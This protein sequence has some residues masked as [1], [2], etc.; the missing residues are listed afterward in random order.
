MRTSDVLLELDRVT[1]DYGHARA[2]DEVSLMVRRREV[3]A[4]LGANGAGKS[5]LLRA[6]S[7]AAG[8]VGGRIEINGKDASGWPTHAVARAGVAH[9]VEGRHVITSMS[10]EDNLLLAGRATRRSS[11]GEIAALL[12]EVYTFFPRLSERR[13]QVS[14]L[15]S[16]GEQQMLALG[17]GIMARPDLLLLDEPSMG[18]APIVIEEI[19][20]FLRRR[21]G[22]LAEAGILLAEQSTALAATV[23]DRACVLSLGRVVFEADAAELDEGRLLKAYLG[24]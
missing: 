12:D 24:N 10:V 13:A 8:K 17:R 5:S 11:R 2:V 22:T 9:V 19:Y 14:G 16:G 3:V 23:A 1:V 7:G 18:L 6:I 4:L 21:A 20:D 15:L